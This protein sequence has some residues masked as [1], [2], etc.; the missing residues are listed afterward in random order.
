V[1][2]ARA[3]ALVGTALSARANLRFQYSQG[4]HFCDIEAK[5]VCF[6]V[7][8]DIRVVDVISTSNQ[9]TTASFRIISIKPA[10]VLAFDTV[11][12]E[13]LKPPTLFKRKLTS[14]RTAQ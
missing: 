2:I 8:E 5:L 14:D 13:L 1:F 11:K 7:T 12:A 10:I 4:R 3:A 9:A 6:R